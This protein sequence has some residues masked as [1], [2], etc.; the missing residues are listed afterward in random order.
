[1]NRLV[2]VS[3][4]VGS[5]REAASAGGLAVA[6]VES[7]RASGGLWFGF[8]GKTSRTGTRTPHTADDDGFQLATLNLPLDEYH[9]YYSGYSNGCLWPICHI[10]PDLIDFERAHFEAY[11]RVNR[12]FA[13]AAAEA[14]E[15]GAT[16]W[17]Q[18]YQLQLVPRML[19][20]T[21]PDLVIGF[22]NLRSTVTPCAFNPRARWLKEERS[23]ACQ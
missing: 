17:V 7:L 1:M 14:A 16:V 6:L 2:V 21:R 12:R 15:E 10:R 11:V 18:D 23:R 5:T 20:E 19:R 4:R 9:G 22:F 3:N 8:S 13:A